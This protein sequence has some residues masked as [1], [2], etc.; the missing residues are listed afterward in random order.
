MTYN[1]GDEVFIT[2]GD[3]RVDITTG[4]PYRVVRVMIT[5]IEIIDDAGDEHAIN[6]DHVSLVVTDEDEGAYE[7]RKANLK[8]T[9]N[10]LFVKG[11]VLVYLDGTP[12]LTTLTVMWCTATAVVFEETYSMPFNPAEFRRKDHDY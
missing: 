3:D 1:I 8:V 11:D 7:E 5:S 6:T 4:K 10:G 12:T 2:D 9:S